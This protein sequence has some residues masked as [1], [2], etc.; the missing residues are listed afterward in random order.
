[1]PSFTATAPGKIILFGEHAVVYGEPALAVP[2]SSVQA[3]AVVSPQVT[4]RWGEIRLEA[5]DVG[6]SK[7]L[8]ELPDRHPL[9]A[10]IEE[11]INVLKLPRFPAC[12][13]QISSTI[14]ISS[15][16][17]SGAAVSA[18]VAR[19]LAGYVGKTL[20]DEQVSA[21]TYEVEKIH[22]GTPSGIDNSVVV[23]R[24]P[25][26]FVKGAPLE[27]LDISVPFTVVIAD[28][29]VDKST[30][31]SVAK[32][33]QGWTR[34][35]VRYET[36]FAFIGDIARQARKLIENGS[37][38][39]IGPLMNENQRLLKKLDVSTPD[40]EHLIAAALDAGAL[41][42]KLSGG[43]L[44]GNIIALARGNEEDIAAALQEAGAAETII[45]PIKKTPRE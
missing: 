41:G 19:A 7:T 30:Q 31:A 17:G 29:G 5:P 22:H 3:R 24:R 6:L 36:L 11:L 43:G 2:V 1:M 13:I 12:R 28:S 37:P 38:L 16:L 26:Y 10:I 34:D 8:E 18:A 25:I 23:Y 35:P 15:G 20:T 40:L 32:V 44:G 33:R 39:D 4:A 45:N 27:T 14:P 42:A 21:L 9:R